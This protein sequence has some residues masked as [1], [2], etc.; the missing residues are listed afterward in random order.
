MAFDHIKN[1]K[2]SAVCCAVPEDKLALEDFYKK[3]DKES[4]ERFVKDTGIRQKFYSKNNKTITSDLCF[5]AAEE[6]IKKKKHFKRRNRRAYLSNA[7]P[8]LQRTRYG[9]NAAI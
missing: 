1:V 2:I 9:D 7:K 6:I 4:V 3:F 8:R 5:A